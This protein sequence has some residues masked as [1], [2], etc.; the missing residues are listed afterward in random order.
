MVVQTAY[1]IDPVGI[2][3]GNLSFTILSPSLVGAHDRVKRI[4][5]RVG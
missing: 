1:S 5:K 3:E 4:V 2:Y